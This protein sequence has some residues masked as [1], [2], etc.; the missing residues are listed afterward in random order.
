MALTFLSECTEE[1]FQTVTNIVKEPLEMAHTSM[2][3]AQ[4]IMEIIFLQQQHVFHYVLTLVTSLLRQFPFKLAESAVLVLLRIG[5]EIW[6][7]V[8][9]CGV[10]GENLMVIQVAQIRGQKNLVVHR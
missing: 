3:I 6:G 1:C 8:V 4:W 7:S 10:E 5:H 2:A 9:V